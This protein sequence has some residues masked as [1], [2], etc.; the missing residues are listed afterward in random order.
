M[1]GDEIK[2]AIQ[3]ALNLRD[4][5]SAFNR[6]MNSNPWVAGFRRVSEYRKDSQR[7]VVKAINNWDNFWY[8]FNT[9]NTKSAV[10]L[11]SE[12]KSE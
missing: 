9:K 1:T 2:T 5:A 6:A 4:C 7:R 11:N 10:N 3:L 8:Q 12:W